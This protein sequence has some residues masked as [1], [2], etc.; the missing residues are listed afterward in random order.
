MKPISRQFGLV[1]VG[2]GPAGIAPLLA[3]HRMGHLDALLAEG[4]AVIE[5]SSK[6]GAGSIGDYAIN[7]DSS[8]TTFVDCLRSPER[9]RLTD[10][11]DH[12]ITRTLATAGERAVPLRDAGR[13]LELVGA[14]LADML[15]A[16]PNC[17]LFTHHEALGMQQADGGWLVTLRDAAGDAVSL[18]SRNVVLAT[19]GHQPSGRL[20]DERV[21]GEPILERYRD[22]L[23]QSGEALRIGGLAHIAGRLSKRG[24]PRIAIVGG[25]TSAAAVAHALLHRLPTISFGVGAVTLLHRRPLRIYYPD[26]ASAL[27]DNYTEFTPRDLCPVSGRVFRL[28]GFRLDSRELMMQARGIGNRPPEPR[29]ALH[30]LQHPADP[31]ALKILD[32]ADLVIAALG[33]RPQALPVHDRNGAPIELLS[34]TGP[35]QPLVDGTCRVQDSSGNATAGIHQ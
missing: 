27:A 9:T 2:G 15:T 7:S 31:V 21:G 26:V 14:V 4:V 18:S 5:K 20:A 35:Q 13:F 12:P 19:G 23:L 16:H 24:N 3:A 34:D 22:K 1:I 10:L 32:K 30:Q 11:A 33:Y 25:S 29:L 17:H 8:G 6:L 28:A